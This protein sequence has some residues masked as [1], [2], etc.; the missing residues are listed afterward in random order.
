MKRFMLVGCVLVG[1]VLAS[2]PAAPAQDFNQLLKAVEK[3]ELNLKELVEQEAQARSQELAK[4]RLEMKAIS[5]GQT[6]QDYQT[7]LDKLAQAI[8]S[9]RLQVQALQ[10]IPPASTEQDADLVSLTSE[11][12]M[13]RTELSDL[14]DRARDKN[15]L[16]LASTG[17]EALAYAFGHDAPAEDEAPEGLQISGFFD[18]VGAQQSSAD[19][20]VNYG[21]GQAEV[22]LEREISDRA[23][24]A[25]AIAYNTDDALFELGAAELAINLYNS[26]ESFMAS[27]DI[28]AGQFD[29]PFGIDFHEYASID[30]KL[31]SG[32]SVVHYTHEGWNDVGFQFSLEASFAN[33]VAFFV[34]GFESSAEVLDEV[35]TLATGVDTYEEVDT[36]PAQAFGARIGFTPINHLEFGGSFATGINADSKNEMILAGADLQYGFSN[37]EI[38]GE[39]IY[40]SLNRSVAKENNSGYYLQGLYDFGT[41]YAISRYGSFKPYESDWVG[42]FSIG[43]GYEVTHGVELRWESLVNEHSDHNAN[44]IQLVAGF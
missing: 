10:T 28:T 42:E 40:H 35:A 31:I 6:G 8:E 17:D 33:M 21:L 19:D 23:S 44:M 36:S 30:N 24:I 20:K 22:D 7:D 12:A 2:A 15:S 1:L 3:I 26:E 29:V 5:T 25:V 39:Y 37:F 18:V 9:L 16:Q 38:K 34:N 4:L 13:L 14:R 43:V 32:P 41:V 27:I 11:V